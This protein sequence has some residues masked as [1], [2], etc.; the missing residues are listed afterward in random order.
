VVVAS[1]AFGCALP[2]AGVAAEEGLAAL[3]REVGAPLLPGGDARHAR[4]RRLARAGRYGDAAAAGAP[5]AGAPAGD[6][7]AARA[8][9]WPAAIATRVD[10]AAAC[11]RCQADE[12]H[13]TP[14]QRPHA[15]IMAAS[16]PIRRLG[17]V[18]SAQ[19]LKLEPQPQEPLEFGLLNLKPAP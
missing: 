19:A 9:G 8:T 3:I 11:E 13:E 18:A 15:L 4:R 17:S 14:R 10:L 2:H 16:G 1:A 7:P 5:A 12:R 6:P